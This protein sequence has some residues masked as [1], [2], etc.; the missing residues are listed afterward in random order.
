MTAHTLI[1]KMDPARA[2]QIT[3]MMCLI[4]NGQAEEIERG[5]A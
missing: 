4:E 5:R 3:A 1:P 2:L